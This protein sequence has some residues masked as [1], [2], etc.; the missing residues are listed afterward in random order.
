M[1]IAPIQ[2]I[3]PSQML[4]STINGTAN[5]PGNQST[6]FGS[7]LSNAMDQVNQISANAEQQ[8]I[9]LASGAAPNIANVMVAATQAQIAVDMT[10]QVRDKVIQAYNQIMNMQV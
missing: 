10:V 2:P 1:S 8:G 6:S 5:V 3:N 9:A 7:F 4:T